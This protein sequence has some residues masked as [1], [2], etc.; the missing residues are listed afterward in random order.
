MS[1]PLARRTGSKPVH[2]TTIVGLI[3][4]PLTV[5]GVLLWGLWNP[6]ER[7]DS[8]TAAVVN[9]D[10]PVEVD[11]QLVPLGRVLA[12]ELIGSAGSSEDEDAEAGGESGGESGSGTPDTNFTWVLT[13]ADDAEAGLAEGRYATVVTIPENFS[14][15]AT[16]LS[17]G[18]EGA[19]TA[20]IDVAESDRGRLIDTALS[21]IVT[22]TA[23]SVLNQQLGSQ[24]VGSVFVGMSELHAGI[25]DAAD[26][27]SQ[28]ADGGAQLAEGAS[29]LADG[30]EQL[31]DGTQQLSS[32]AGELST[33]AAQVATGAG[34]LSAGA[35]D[36][37]AG[38]AGLAAGVRS[39]A[40]GDGTPENPGL[41]GYASGVRLLVSG[42]G[43]E[44]N[45]GLTNYLGGVDTYATGVGGALAQLRDGITAG[46]A[47]LI[48]YRDGL[49]N[50]TIPPPQDVPV[51]VLVGILDGLIAQIEAQMQ[52]PEVQEQLAR[53]DGLIVAS[54]GIAAGARG[55]GSQLEPIAAGA[56]GLAAGAEQL[57]TGA[58]DFAGGASQFAGG[59]AQFAGGTAELADGASQL[60]TG[61]SEL[62]A[63]TPELAEGASQLAEGA[64]R[65]AEGTAELAEGLGEAA[66]GIP[67]YTEAERETVAQT[68]V[69][70][71]EARGGSDEL[72]NASGVPLFAGI[73]LWA[74]ALASFLVLAPLWRRTRDAAR[75]VGWIALRSAG[76][77]V[78]IGAAQGAIAGVVLPVALG[79]DLARGAAFF[80]MALLAGIAFA[81]VVQGLSALLGGLGRFIAFVLLVVAFAVG[82]VSTVPAGLAAVGDASPLGSALAGFQAIATEAS[83]AGIAAVLLVLWGLG[84]LV[85]TALAVARARKA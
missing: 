52:S 16:S 21:S 14:A 37:S 29:Q 82:I 85:L 12:G 83:G 63:G 49:Q 24:F 31:S 20:Y 35:G 81:L 47:E 2:W 43:T 56:E 44:G 77:A 71:V 11:G 7:L 10:E 28:L 51:E 38:S 59:V 42:D 18:P 68:A 15:A 65:S 19:Q 73:A 76:P 6:T 17:D 30:T 70:P 64:G 23:T 74:G 60:A 75:G 3:L 61:T 55:Y 33:G 66:S 67:D 1:L 45:P 13:D 9:E 79:Y 34:E 80:G 78:A 40:S 39:F 72:F 57:A 32:G 22:Q 41:R 50:G 84:G 58:E 54:D 62:A 46:P 25:G 69:T 36:L 26:G 8:V 53:L 5:A 4:V 27:A 48:A